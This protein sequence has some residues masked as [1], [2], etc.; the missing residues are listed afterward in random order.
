MSDSLP[1]P[2]GPR[3][4][5]LRAG[6]QGARAYAAGAPVLACPYGPTRPFARR[7]WIEG[8]A[9]AQRAAGVPSAGDRAEE[10]DDAAP[11]PGDTPPA[12]A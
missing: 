4:V 1:P 11:W 7:S 6:L 5:A 12:N 10:V 8:Y 9:A 2:V 3:G